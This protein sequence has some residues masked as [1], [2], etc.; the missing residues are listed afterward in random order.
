MIRNVLFI[1][2]DEVKLQIA[3]GAAEYHVSQCNTICN[4]GSDI[5]AKIPNI[6]S[7]MKKD[8]ADSIEQI[9]NKL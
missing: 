1:F 4:R 5:G 3:L 9:K 7:F 2:A 6:I 8:Q